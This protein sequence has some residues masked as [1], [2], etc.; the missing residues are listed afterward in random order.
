V[1]TQGGI[2]ETFP[3]MSEL[4]HSGNSQNVQ[5]ISGLPRYA[6]MTMQA[7]Q[8]F[9]LPFSETRRDANILGGSE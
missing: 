8:L 5:M 2:D 9:G 6:H 7:W 4:G 3:F 1:T